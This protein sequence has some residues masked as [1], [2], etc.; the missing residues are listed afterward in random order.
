MS[1]AHPKS[2]NA[3]RRRELLAAA[4]AV[5]DRNWT[6][7]S[8]IPAPGI[9]PHQWSWDT[10]FIAIGRSW[11]DGARGAAELEHLFA[12]RWANGMVPHIRFGPDTTNYFPGPDFWQARRSAAAPRDIE[13]SGITQPPNRAVAALEIHRR[14]RGATERAAAGACLERIYP[15]LVAQHDYLARWRDPSGIDLAAILP[16]GSRASTTPP[17]GIAISTSS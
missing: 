14:A 10:G 11:G 15:R 9:Y 7:A 5:L 8:T 3:T 1:R 13:T 6:G 17:P 16:R 12:A 2:P 4:R